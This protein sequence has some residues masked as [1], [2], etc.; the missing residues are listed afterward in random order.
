MK[1]DMIQMVWHN[2]FQGSV[3]ADTVLES[4]DAMALTSMLFSENSLRSNRTNRKDPDPQGVDLFPEAGQRGV[5]T[6]FASDDED[7]SDFLK[8]KDGDVA[9]ASPAEGAKAYVGAVAP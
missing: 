6:S 2:L 9:I 3:Q 5:A 8:P 7:K 1:F 4:G